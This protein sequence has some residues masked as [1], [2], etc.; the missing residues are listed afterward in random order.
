MKWKTSA[1]EFK[2]QFTQ[3]VHWGKL[4]WNAHIPPSRSLLLWRVIHN[5]LPTDEN[6]AT[7]GLPYPSMCSNC[8]KHVENS[9]HLF[10]S[11]PFAVHLWRHLSSVLVHNFQSLDDIWI[12]LN[13]PWSDQRKVV[14]L[15]A[16]INTINAICQARNK[17]RFKD[18]KTHWKTAIS[19][20]ILA[21]SFSIS[22]NLTLKLCSNSI[23]DFSVMKSFDVTLHHPKTHFTKEI[24]WHPPAMNWVKCNTDI[25]L[26]VVRN[27][28]LWW[29]L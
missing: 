24:L 18:V 19:S 28:R 13:K 17:V 14:V 8:F 11:C 5:R 27:C 20:I 7:R 29:D 6:L 12:A 25:L 10:F 21:V 26:V 23:L 9:E 15:S 22:G 16:I 1:F 2:A 4:I 3:V